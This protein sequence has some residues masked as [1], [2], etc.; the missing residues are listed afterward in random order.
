[1]SRSDYTE[2]QRQEVCS[3]WKGNHVAKG[4]TSLEATL[5]LILAGY[6]QFLGK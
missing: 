4:K 1:M 5:E 6:N 3:K 2:V